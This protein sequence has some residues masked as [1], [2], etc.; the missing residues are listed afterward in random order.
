MKYKFIRHVPTK[1]FHLKYL[2]S[3]VFK[4][5]AIITP[6]LLSLILRIILCA[7][8]S[9]GI[10]APIPALPS[11]LCS[12]VEHYICHIS[13]PPLAASLCRSGS[14]LKDSLVP[15]DSCSLNILHHSAG[16][17]VS[18]VIYW[19]GVCAERMNDNQAFVRP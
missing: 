18:S 2:N 19:A 11:C 9:I 16:T 14:S 7:D 4:G 5:A 3:A 13:A 6:G 10:R 15:T 17:C 1:M 12:P 8:M